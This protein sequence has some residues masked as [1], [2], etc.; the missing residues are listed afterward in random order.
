[1]SNEQNPDPMQLENDFKQMDTDTDG[2][3][4]KEDMRIIDLDSTDEELKLLFN[5]MDT[6]KDGKVSLSEY[7]RV[8]Q[9]Q[10]PDG[11]VSDEEKYASLFKILDSDSDGFISKEDLKLLDPNLT[12]EDISVTFNHLD[13]NKDGKASQVDFVNGMLLLKQGNK[14]DMEEKDVLVLDIGVQKTSTAFYLF[15]IYLILHGLFLLIHFMYSKELPKSFY[16]ISNGLLFIFYS[17]LFV[18]IFYY[19]LGYYNWLTFIVWWVQLIM[20]ILY[21]FA[22]VNSTMIGMQTLFL[23]FLSVTF[24]MMIP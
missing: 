13:T 18:Y 4:V 19:S 5:M 15:L 16:I 1:M 10:I 23:V 3:I 7:K 17:L 6:D 14:M 24:F 21:M 22:P 11:D 8:M 20:T 12:E 9:L 2:F